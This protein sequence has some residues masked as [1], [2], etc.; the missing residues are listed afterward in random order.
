VAATIP[1]LLAV[2]TSTVAALSLYDEFAEFADA[3][4]WTA[5]VVAGLALLFAAG[6]RIV[7]S[8]KPARTIFGWSSMILAS[9]AVVV[10]IGENV[11]IVVAASAF[12]LVRIL[13]IGAIPHTWLSWPAWL[14]PVIIAMAAGHALGVPG[15]S[16]YLLS[17]S[18]GVA[19]LIGSLVFDDV[20][21]TRRAI[22]EGLR[23]PWLRYPFVIGLVAVPL[24][25][26][27][28]F[29]LGATTVG[30]AS[31]TAAAGYLVVAILLR[32][33]SVTFP[34]FGLAVFGTA[35][36]LPQSSVEYPWM[37]VVMAAMIVIWSFIIERIQSQEAA[38]SPWTRWDLPALVVAHVITIVALLLT[39]DGS[40]DPATWIAAG[41]LSMMVGIW[42][43]NRWWMDT[44]LL[45]TIVG[46]AIAGE[47]WLIMAL[48]ITTAR[49]MYGVWRDV[50]IHRYVDHA[51]AVAGFVA[52]WADLAV[53]FEL[54]HIEIVS[55]GSMTAGFVAVVVAIL[56]RQNL[57]KKDTFVLWSTL[58]A[59]G[60]L[61]AMIVGFSAV[62]VAITGPW[63]GIGITLVAIS[64]EQW[65]RTL[66]PNVR[67][68]TPFL[69][70]VGWL[71]LL[72]GLGLSDIASTSYTVATF[73][74]V[75]ALMMP[76]ADRLVAR[77]D[78][79]DV[80]HLIVTARIW[81]VVA[82]TG[83]VVAGSEAVATDTRG[84]WWLVAAGL[85]FT[86]IAT[87][88][89]S[90]A[91]DIARLRS[92]S[93][94][95]ALGALGA[96]L[97][98][99]DVSPFGIGV[100]MTTVASVATLFS[101]VLVSRHHNSSWIETGVITGIAATLL[102]VPIA[103]TG[104]PATEL[105]VLILVVI[106]GQAIAYGIVFKR[107]MLIAAG[108]PVLGLAAI[109]LA[110][111]S[112]S[113]SALWYT[114][115]V[116]IVM[117]AEADLLQPM[118]SNDSNDRRSLAL[119]ILEWSGV[120]LIGIPPLIEMFRTNVAFGLVGFA[121]AVGL[122]AWALLTKVK[123]RVLAACVVATSSTMLSLAAAAASNVQDSAG[124]WIVGGGIGFSIMLI[125]GFVE[126]YRSR[127]GALMRRLGD[128][129]EEWE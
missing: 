114:V 29:A 55:Y 59:S 119:L 79:D 22:G 90:R 6:A 2:I 81:A 117:L 10:A 92:G 116:A 41:A 5:V 33:G 40:P 83:I 74:L 113:G 54:T 64:S 32:A 94:I 85:A 63:V 87:A 72:M 24:S 98:A 20:A 102:A 57:A 21:N 13:L 58:G 4:P 69:A 93:G 95:P 73:G 106:G 115:P 111:E 1:P 47:P 11:P 52:A 70:A 123:R 112:A 12:I 48:A 51:I 31:L 110:V 86:T 62:P 105:V 82:L 37:L 7:V 25:L 34:A 127:S 107:Q 23:T 45:L 77:A 19:M 122:M 84:M 96:A 60:V 43:K 42:R 44:G 38:A 75:L 126:A 15:Q 17:L 26:A 49:G 78:A 129:M 36:L 66:Y 128:L 103:I 35:V 99:L 108:P 121:L 124:F 91:I 109:A 89:G 71:A 67:Y 8:T 27:P 39:L 18:T 28:V 65:A 88:T 50:G 120:A 16:V 100:A 76:I 53:W 30:V 46:S 101:V 14:M 80:Q 68:A 3:R 97:L 104:Y 118:L 61:A 9:A 125:A 56:S